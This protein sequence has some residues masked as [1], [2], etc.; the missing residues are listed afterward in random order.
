MRNATAAIL[1][2]LLVAPSYAQTYEIRGGGAASCGAW[3]HDRAAG[4]NSTVRFGRES[5]LMGYI[6]AYNAFVFPAGDIA[7][8]VDAFGL[9]GWIDNFCTSHPLDTIGSAA[10]Q[11][12]AAL[13]QK[14][15]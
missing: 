7:E 2:L 4:G 12:T 11:L 3:L 1:I 8:G 6:T 10:S 13:R 15:R 14:L 9:F 5:W